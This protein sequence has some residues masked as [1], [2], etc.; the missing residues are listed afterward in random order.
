MSMKRAKLLS[1]GLIVSFM[2]AIGVASTTTALWS[3]NFQS[4]DD[5]VTV[6]KDTT[7][8]GSLY[9]AGN[10]V[11][12]DGTVTGSVYCGGNI[13]TINGTV[14]GDVLCAGQKVTING[15]VGGD[16][17]VA[18]QF[19]QLS[20][21]VGGSLTAFAQDVRLDQSANVGG[22]INGA[23]QQFTINGMVGRDIA[24]GTQLLALDSEVKGNVDVAT[25][26]IQLGSRASVL[27]NFNYGAKKEISF[28]RSLVNG[29]VSFNPAQPDDYNQAGHQFAA[30]ARVSLLLMLAVS[31]IVMILIAPRFIDRS[32]ELFRS[33]ALMTVLLGF[34]IVFGGP[35]IVGLL[36]FSLVLAPLGLALLFGW[37]AIIFLSGIFFAYMIGAE[38]LRSQSNVIVRMLGG[39]AIVTIAYMIPIIS[40][41]V[42]F[43]SLIVGSGMIVMTFT[44]GYRRPRYNLRAA[45]KSHTTKKAA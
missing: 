4:S 42:L 38:L 13:V 29:E 20:G 2:A 30:A 19:I 31:A 5:T 21:K 41:I 40:A 27:G 15:T 22:D 18:G 10:N 9:A 24:V 23:A 37:L 43:I 28:D 16:V 12:V 33:Q 7:H 25:E 3:P 17:R 32:S 39:V 14:E 45:A 36:L 6:A 44:H 11:T 8:T 35:I 1:F 26:Q 34:A